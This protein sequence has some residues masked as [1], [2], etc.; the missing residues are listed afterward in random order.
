MDLLSLDRPAILDVYGAKMLR[1]IFRNILK[2]KK[3]EVLIMADESATNGDVF[4]DA[5]IGTND[6]SKAQM[7]M[8]T[9]LRCKQ[10]R[11]SSVD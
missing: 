6:D 9:G 2:G 7:R 1:R 3:D 4:D 8:I 11:R 10:N 5:E